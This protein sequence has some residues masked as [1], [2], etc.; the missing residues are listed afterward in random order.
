MVKY[1]VLQMNEPLVFVDHNSNLGVYEYF[2]KSK[3]DNNWARCKICDSRFKAKGGS[4]GTLRKHLTKAHPNK[5]ITE[6]TNRKRL[7]ADDEIVKSSVPKITRYFSNDKQNMAFF[8]SR[9]AALDGIPYQKFCTS[10]DL[11]AY[12]ATKESK[13]VPISPHTFKKMVIDFGSEV[14]SDTVKKLQKVKSNAISITLDE[15]TSSAFK[16]Y[17]NI[18]VH[19][20]GQYINLGLNRIKGSL[21]TIKCVELVKEVLISHEIKIEEVV[22]ITSDGA[23]VMVAM[24]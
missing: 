18:N 10:V 17:M 9:M 24:G 20:D 15:W 16:R 1:D 12:L 8:V 19:F 23:S 6:V 3:P 22:G 2:Q 5:V 4:N 7:A 21:P 11:R 14:C 13:P